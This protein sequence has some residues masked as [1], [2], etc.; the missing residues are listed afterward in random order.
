MNAGV[1]QNK[2]RVRVRSPKELEF[3]TLIDTSALLRSSFSAPRYWWSVSSALDAVYT[4]KRLNENSSRDNFSKMQNLW[5]HEFAVIGT[6]SDL[7]ILICFFRLLGKTC[8][9]ALCY[10]TSE[11]SECLYFRRY[12]NFFL[13]IILQKTLLILLLMISDRSIWSNFITKLALIYLRKKIP[14]FKSEHTSKNWQKN[15]QQ[16]L[17]KVKTPIKE[18]SDVNLLSQR[19]WKTMVGVCPIRAKVVRIRQKTWL[20]K[21]TLY[22]QPS[23]EKVPASKGNVGFQFDSPRTTIGRYGK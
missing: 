20:G 8:R 18:S 11:P 9:L 22:L 7:R 16:S 13:Q 19:C 2:S 4:G 3:K 1:V 21:Q 15:F 5:R 12:G 17:F 23:K 6:S 10:Q 14:P